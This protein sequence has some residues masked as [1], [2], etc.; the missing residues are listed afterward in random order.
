MWVRDS[1]AMV[2]LRSGSVYFIE[3]YLYI[4]LVFESQCKHQESITDVSVATHGDK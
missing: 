3:T 4:Y 2:A 1:T